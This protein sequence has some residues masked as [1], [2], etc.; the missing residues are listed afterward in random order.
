[1]FL[2]DTTLN[3]ENMTKNLKKSK[4][5]IAKVTAGDFSCSI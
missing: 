5:S 4:K 2:S 1:M 3:V